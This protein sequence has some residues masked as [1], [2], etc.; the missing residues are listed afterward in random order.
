MRGVVW[1]RRGRD[2]NT[3]PTER[4]MR[5]LGMLALGLSGLA[6]GALVG[7]IVAFGTGL[8]VLQC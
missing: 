3:S 6:V 2:T 5:V 4:I 1:S 8:L 7:L